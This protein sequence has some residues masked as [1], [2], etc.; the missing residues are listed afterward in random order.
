MLGSE[1][2]GGRKGGRERERKRAQLEDKWFGPHSVGKKVVG[3]N[4][5]TW[6]KMQNL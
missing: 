1:R 2:W 4:E 3:W 5:N 6:E